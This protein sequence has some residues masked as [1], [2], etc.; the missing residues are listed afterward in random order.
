M[1]LDDRII[2]QGIR[3]KKLSNF[4]DSPSEGSSQEESTSTSTKKDPIKVK[5]KL[6]LH[7][8]EEKVR[9]ILNILKN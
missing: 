4:S 8:I 7:G 5:D 3:Q 9:Q 6:Y 2:Q 1:G